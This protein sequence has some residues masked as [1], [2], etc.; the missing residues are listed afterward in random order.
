M[1]INILF[2]LFICSFT[3]VYAQDDFEQYRKQAQ[4]EY[5]GFRDQSVKEFNDYRDKANAE[6]ADYV[7]QSWES[8][9][10]FQGIPIPKEPKPVIPPKV[11]PTPDRKP[12]I[13][14]VPFKEIK[15]LPTVPVVQPQ[16]I[17]PIPPTPRPV[18]QPQG[19]KTSP[20]KPRFTFSYYG[21][22]GKVS[23]D[24]SHRFLL[25]DASENSVADAWE[26]LSDSRYNDLLNDCLTLRKELNLS[27]WGYMELLKTMSEKQFGKPCNEAVLMQMFILSQ[28]GYKVRIARIENKLVLLV[29]FQE[30]MY[31]YVY[32]PINGLN[33]YVLDKSFK[34]G[35]FNVLNHEFPKEQPASLKITQPN[36]PVVATPTKTFTSKYNRDLRVTVSTNKNLIDFYKNY[37]LSNEWNLYAQASLS[38]QLKQDLYPALQQQIAGKSERD[39]ANILLQFVQTAFN[40]QTDEQQFGYERPLFA[41]ESFFYPANDCED[42]SILFAN[43]VKDL[44]HLDVVLLH[45]PGHLATAV[46]FNET[47]QGDYLTIKGNKFIV[48]DPTYTGASIGMAMP[49]LKTT[50]AEVV[51]V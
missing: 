15:P 34:G 47:I 26:T 27:D 5:T 17:A 22:E 24:A 39:A 43:L 25:R 9:Q 3:S 11:E 33:Y 38:E 51:K 4:Q 41:D 35:Q 19:A 42:R 49:Q 2:L 44:L 29:P 10:A 48:C 21:S 31:Q 32:I 45:Y 14:P 40:Y 30:T 36:F 28:S 12:T 13:D 20:V 1:K 8:F 7:R 18:D 37:P 46:H 6:F 50:S 16:P 23:L